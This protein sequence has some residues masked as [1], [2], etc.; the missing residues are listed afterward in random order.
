MTVLST[1][2]VGTERYFG[3]GPVPQPGVELLL[4]PSARTNWLTSFRNREATPTP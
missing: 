3:L 4:H 1:Y 2:A